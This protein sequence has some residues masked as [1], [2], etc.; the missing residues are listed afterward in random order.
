V[1][2][3][4][5]AAGIGRRMSALAGERHKTLL[6]IGPTT[7]LGRV[8]EG[9]ASI[10]VTD[11]TVVTGHRDQD[12]RA[13]LADRFPAR[14]F[15]F[16]HNPRYAETNNIVSLALALEQVPLDDDVALIESDLLF[17]PAVLRSLLLPGDD[18]LALVDRWRP[19]LDGT[20]VSI[21]DGLV[22]HVYP[23]HLQG[24]RFDLS[25]KYKTLNIYRFGKEFLQKRFKP[26]LDCY[27]NYIDGNVYYELV[28]GMLVNMQRERIRAVVVEAA[29][30]EVDDPNDFAV[31]RYTFEPD[32]RARLLERAA[33][34]HWNF[35]LLDF[36]YLRNLHFPPD[37][38]LAAMRH[39]LPQLVASYGSSQQV[40]DEK[41]GWHL[42][43]PASRVATLHGA[44]QIYPWLPELLSPK[45]VLLP[46]PTFGEYRRVFPQHAVYSDS[47]GV[48][49]EELEEKARQSDLVV[50]VNPN[51]PTGTTL[52]TQWIWQ[53]ASRR[54]DVRF[55]VDESFVDFCGEESLI[56]RLQ[57]EPLPNVLVLKSLSKTLGVP[58]LRLGYAYTCDA[59]LL[60]AIRAR[61][62]IWNLGA[63]AEHFLELS[64]KF[65]PELA[66]SFTRTAADR[67]DLAARLQAL[68]QI[69]RV[70]PSGGNFL[71][72]RLADGG[73]ERGAHLVAQLLARERIFLKDVSARLQP[74]AP[75]LRFA[76]RRPADHAR[77]V[78]A[79]REAL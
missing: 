47:P 59:A 9:L 8:V 45:S 40:L 33:G 61:I 76:V 70:Y 56:A 52:S 49:L 32:E 64:L 41:L 30:A 39:A 77:L 3:I 6:P 55:L 46:A 20:V 60:A 48:N 10:G 29:W 15:R 18:T 74:E 68:P 26:L 58:G 24:P 53:L 42:M 75:W 43:V 54:R 65:R 51:N 21:E 67:E 17:E 1:K 37:A 38:M 23:P 73:P 25:D 79:L 22:S 63:T 62:P 14:S 66:A 69:A 7:I 34:G 72:A 16:V 2:A 11:V 50:I 36:H 19:G 13:F 5:L 27:A 71:L 44:S 78:A 4:V 12:V 57:R 28:L 35:D 31:A